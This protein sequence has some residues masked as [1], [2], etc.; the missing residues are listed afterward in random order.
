MKKRP[1]VVDDEVRARET[2]YLTLACDHRIIDGVTAAQFLA[3]ICAELT[4][5]GD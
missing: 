1:F 2:A 5:E 4:G 3:R